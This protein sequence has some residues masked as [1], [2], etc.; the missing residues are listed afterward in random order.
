MFGSMTERPTA[1]WSFI[2]PTL[3]QYVCDDEHNNVG[4]RF[5]IAESHPVVASLR[6][7]ARVIGEPCDPT[8]GWTVVADMG[9]D[10]RGKRYLAMHDSEDGAVTVFGLLQMHNLY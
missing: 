10:E 7:F 6:E 1:L 8:T 9:S 4:R 3:R 5:T 2:T